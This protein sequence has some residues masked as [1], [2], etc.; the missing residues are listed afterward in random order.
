MEYEGLSI[1]SGGVKGLQVLGALG[2]LDLNEKL[3]KIRYYSGCSIGSIITLLMAVGWRPIELYRRTKSITIF[4]G[5]GSINLR[6]LKDKHGLMSNDKLRKELETLVIEKRQAKGYPKEKWLPTFLDMHQEGI[7]I[8]FTIVDRRTRRGH[9]IDYESHPSLAVTEGALMSSNVPLIFHPIE[10]EGMQV[11]DGAL[12]N[13]FPVDYLDRINRKNHRKGIEDRIKILG[14]VIYGIPN[15]S[16][17]SFMTYLSDTISIP[18][19]EM[20]RMIVRNVSRH[21]DILE[22]SVQEIS[23]LGLN[24]SIDVRNDLFFAGFDDGRILIDEL[25][26]A[27]KSNEEHDK[28]GKKNKEKPKTY[29]RTP[30]TILPKDVLLKCLMCQPLDIL[31]QAAL[32]G[33][34]SLQLCLSQIP[35]DRLFR[36]EHLARQII[37]KEVDSGTYIKTEAPPDPT[38]VNGD[39]VKIR[40]N[41]SQKLYDH[42]PMQ[43]KATAKV[44]VDSL[45]PEKA[46]S[47]IN[48]INIVIEG[49]RHLG[50]D[51]FS[52]FLISNDD[53]RSSNSNDKD[54]NNGNNNNEPRQEVHGRVEIV[55]DVVEP[56]RKIEEID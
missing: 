17:D 4:N 27:N 38:Y 20:Q 33:S 56:K 8:A 5:M 50:I 41:Y 7:Y 3:N 2:Y 32:T 18:I 42:L 37:K 44:M 45:P 31:C 21:V 52:G 28:K 53:S 13:P 16:D 9:K 34:K 11:I 51:V 55:E 23:L 35:K 43:F 54:S 14:I 26:S 10:F 47:T 24:D 22:M 46:Q 25:D 49:L 19:E 36:L 40:E 12:A 1:S 29:V 15:P 39:K 6:D 30:I 48:G